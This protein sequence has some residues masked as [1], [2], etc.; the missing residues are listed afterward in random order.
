MDA[1]LV[2]LGVGEDPVE[3]D[4]VARAALGPVRGEVEG[5]APVAVEHGDGAGDQHLLE[6]VPVEATAP[7]V[8]PASCRGGVTE[9]FVLRFFPLKILM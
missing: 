5:V 3:G 4:G 9:I 2:H 1:P 7:Q 8:I 6:G